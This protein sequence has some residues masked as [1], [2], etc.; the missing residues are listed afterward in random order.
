MSA[1]ARHTGLSFSMISQL[2]GS[3]PQTEQVKSPNG[4]TTTSSAERL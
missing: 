1:Q 4:E 3:T 2:P